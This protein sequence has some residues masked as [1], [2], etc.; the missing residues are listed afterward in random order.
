MRLLWTIAAAVSLV[1]GTPASSPAQNH[2]SIDGFGGLTLGHLSPATDF[3]STLDFGGRVAVN[4]VPEVQA[5]GEFGRL[6]NVLPPFTDLLSSLTPLDIRASALYGEGGVRFLVAPRSTVTPYV[7]ATAGLARLRFRLG[8]LGTS[9]DRAANLLLGFA[10]TTE[11][12]AGVGGGIIVRGG[13]VVLDLG[14]RYKQIMG[15]NFVQSTLGLGQHLRS[16]QV[17]VGVGVRF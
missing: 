6:G 15:N 13:P 14:Y 8:G 1:I 16:N 9:A 11:P 12:V 5:I 17:R 7:E 4:L 10:G 3:S 2:G